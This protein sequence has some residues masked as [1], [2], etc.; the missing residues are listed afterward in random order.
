MNFTLQPR[1]IALILPVL[2]SGCANFYCD[3]CNSKT[4]DHHK[5]LVHHHLSAIDSIPTQTAV[6]IDYVSS[7]LLPTS[8]GVKLIANWHATPHTQ[9]FVYYQGVFVNPMPII[10]P[11]GDR[12]LLDFRHEP[13]STWGSIYL[14]TADGQPT[15]PQLA[16]S[17][18]GWFK[19]P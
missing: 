12:Y 17:T 19:V 15:D 9:D 18:V 10:T 6:Q 1:H 4:N 3:H 5:R 13:D 16:P 8:N 2:L 14:L 11:K 7:S